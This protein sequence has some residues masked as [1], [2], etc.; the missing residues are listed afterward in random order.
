MVKNP[1]ASARDGGLEEIYSCLGNSV[2]RG[3]WW[4]TVPGVMT[5]QLSTIHTYTIPRIDTV[6]GTGDVTVNKILKNPCLHVSYI[7]AKGT[8]SK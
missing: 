3:A 2:D 6:R 7:L 4:A 1:P 8:D 5:E